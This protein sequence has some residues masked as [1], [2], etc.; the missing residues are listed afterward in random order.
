[1]VA[2]LGAVGLLPAGGARRRRSSFSFGIRRAQRD[3]G[4]ALLVA[5]TVAVALVA[6]CGR[7][8]LPRT[9]RLAG[10]GE[11][12]LALRLPE[13]ATAEETERELSHLERQLLKMPEISRE[14]AVFGAG[15]AAVIAQLSP[16]AQRADRRERLLTR[17]A[18]GLHS[19]AALEVREGR[20]LS[21]GA[22][23]GG[24][25]EQRAD[26][27]ADGR[28]YRIVLR[29][30]DLPA[31]GEAHARIAARL[32]ALVGR[33]NWS[34]EWGKSSVRLVLQPVP[35]LPP[36]AAMAL[37]GHLRRLSDEPSTLA[38]PGAGERA[39]RVDIAGGR[40]AAPQLADL[41]RLWRDSH[42]A[43]VSPANLVQVRKE[44]VTPRLV[45]E[46]GRFAVTIEVRF[47]QQS[48]IVR[49]AKRQTVDNQLRHLR[50]PAGCDLERPA[51][52]RPLGQPD[53]VRPAVLWVSVPLLL[54]TIGV[55][56]SGSLW[57]G[58]SALLPVLLG[59]LLAAPVSMASRGQ[60]DELTLFAVLAAAAA[61]LAI[62][63]M[64][65][66][67][68]GGR[69]G[70]EESSPFR[71]YRR[72]RGEEGWLLVAAL[73]APAAL[74]LATLG[75]DPNGA[76]WVAPLRAA[77]AVMG[78]G[79]VACALLAPLL[80]ITPLRRRRQAV[81]LPVAAAFTRPRLAVHSLV[82]IYGNGHRALAGINF[83]LA[84]GVVGLLGPN[85]AGKTTLLRIL[86][87]L[88]E[89]TRGQVS[90]GGVK[91]TAGN[92]SE[93]RRQ[94]GFLPQDFNAYPGFTAEQFLDYWAMKRGIGPPTVRRAEVESLLARV[95]LAEHANRKVRDF[96]GGMRKRVGIARALLGAPP[97]II[98]DEPT[99]GLDLESRHAFRDTL[100]TVASD[101]IVVFST[102]IASDVE[103][104]AHLI[105]LLYGGHLLFSGTPV[106]L[107]ATA[108]GRVFE[109]T[110]CEAELREL[111]R[112][113]RL[114]LRIRTAEGVKVRGVAGD[115]AEP[116]PGPAVEPS[117][118]EGYLFALE[119]FEGVRRRGGG[120]ERF[121]F[122]EE[123]R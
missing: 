76:S 47:P 9:A 54:L 112:R 30:N 60:I 97:I 55:G 94:V 78:G 51:L 80:G 106:E 113:H 96:S 61:C 110:V 122:L 88:L 87:G 108:R 17:L 27:D 75:V 18:Y 38:L 63:V 42:G 4:T 71:I 116:L 101:R 74:G 64:L 91:V 93:Y 28:R 53:W 39:L 111:E 117:L 16:A 12:T 56:W 31:L 59:L 33:D 120:G 99:T 92:L 15:R 104:T 37:A 86:T 69:G 114:T 82:K 105:L 19:S 49:L 58:L 123:G 13:G 90:L 121:A 62:A 23:E 36:D 1:V 45:R 24:A 32:G 40:T 83:E 7:A 8:L 48:E 26:A 65:V 85:G 22:W 118:E 95:G 89:P 100:L 20:D 102:H 119:G 107:A 11:I 68:L 66:C 34:S 77:A 50:L 103:S 14:W 72:W 6:L 43:V 44:V 81:P 109:T 25:F 67:R 5:A 35:G 52:D 41:L 79:S 3:P 46:W 70:A 115:P 21:A 98:V 10:D 73:V 2:G 29:G 84:P 57:S